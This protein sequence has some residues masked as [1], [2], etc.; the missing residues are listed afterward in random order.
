MAVGVTQ[1]GL[2]ITETDD[3]LG[4]QGIVQMCEVRVQLE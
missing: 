3:L 4:L 1:V 2:I